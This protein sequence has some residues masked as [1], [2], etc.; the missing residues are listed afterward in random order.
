MKR[1]NFEK[2]GS[3]EIDFHTDSKNYEFK[4]L[5]IYLVALI[6]YIL[7]VLLFSIVLSF[8]GIENIALSILI[9]LIPGVIFFFLIRKFIYP[10]HIILY[11][12]HFE[13]D[14]KMMECLENL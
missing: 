14:S 8:F 4:L 13:K 2:L 12:H 11:I 5:S 9:S 3:D 7:Y 1:I 10:L 6:E